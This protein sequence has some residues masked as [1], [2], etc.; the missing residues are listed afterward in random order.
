[1]L[2]VIGASVILYRLI[3]NRAWSGPAAASA[4]NGTIAALARHLEGQPQDQ[5]GWISLGAAYG[6]D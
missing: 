2:G 4:D 3:G 6:G 1:M 5:S